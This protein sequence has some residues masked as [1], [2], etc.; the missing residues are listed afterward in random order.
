VPANGFFAS[1]P[2][3][4]GTISATGTLPK[5]GWAAAE[6]RHSATAGWESSAF[7]TSGAAMLYPLETIM[8]SALAKYRK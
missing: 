1:A 7:S 6:T 2:P 8:S 4:A 5:V 3:P